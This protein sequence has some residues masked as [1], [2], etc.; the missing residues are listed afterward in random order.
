MKTEQFKNWL[1]EVKEYKSNV[2]QSR[3]TNCRKVERYFDLD[4][5]FLKDRGCELLALLA[6]STED[7]RKRL[8]TKHNIPIDGNL[9][10]GS[11]TLK[12]A[13]NLYMCFLE[14]IRDKPDTQIQSNQKPKTDN[15]RQVTQKQTSGFHRLI[16]NN[17][18]NI[19]YK[20]LFGDYLKGATEFI[21]KDPYI[22][23]PYQLRNFMELCRLIAETK[24]EGATIRI[25]L[26]TFY[27]EEYLKNAKLAFDEMVY[28]LSIQGLDLSYEFSEDQHD[29][30]I[31][32]NNGW[33]IILGRGLDIW[34]KT[35][36]R[37]DIAEYDQEKR[38]CKEFELTVVKK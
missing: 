5:H 15:H 6:Y 9:R 17:Q 23:M 25:N 10:T 30:S 28:S 13:V 11:A 19:S 21:I 36:G 7:Q 29:R 33:K 16:K 3:I 2:V 8:P 34:Q 18:N 12:S 4:S 38:L 31:E 20:N 1:I 22:R 26:V 37:F 24:Q 35:N 27:D 14:D 32:M